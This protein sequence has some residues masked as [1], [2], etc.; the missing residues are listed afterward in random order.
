MGQTIVTT[1]S[2]VLALVVGTL[3][4]PMKASILARTKIREERITK[5]ER[6][7][8]ASKNIVHAVGSEILLA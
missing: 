7:V 6:F 5:T 3:L 8:T 4:E 2:T 1:I